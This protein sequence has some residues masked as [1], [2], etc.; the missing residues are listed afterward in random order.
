MSKYENRKKRGNLPAKVMQKYGYIFAHKNMVGRLNKYGRAWT[1]RT[2]CQYNVEQVLYKNNKWH[3]YKNK[4]VSEATRSSRWNEIKSAFHD[5]HNLNFKIVYPYSITRH[6]VVALTRS[7]EAEG[8]APSSIIQKYSKLSVFLRWINKNHII[9]GLSKDDLYKEPESFVRHT[10]TTE[11]KSWKNQNVEEILDK[12]EKKDRHIADQLKLSMLFGMRAK[13]SMLFR[14][15]L[16]YNRIE[17]KLF[18]RRGTKNGR[19]RTVPVET[20]EEREFLE[21]LIESRI[22]RNAS[23]V[24][25]MIKLKKWIKY[26][27][28][29]L[30]RCGVS[31]KNGMTPHGLRHFYAH[32][33][34]E[35]ESGKPA[36]VLIGKHTPINTKSIDD[37]IARRQVSERLGHSRPSIASAYIGTE[38]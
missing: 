1:C 23:M 38:D 19:A 24:P 7:W 36:P 14:P 16:D 29:V 32:R 37:K 5:L 22:E 18:L 15:I 34:Y 3:S 30:N 13:E 2:V 33:I 4:I 21:Y 31:R 17:Q 25:R 20:K 9:D 27:Y 12:I 6:H 8:L 28:R 10:A 35:Q 11:D 26:Y